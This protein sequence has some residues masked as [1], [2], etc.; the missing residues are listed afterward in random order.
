MFAKAPYARWVSAVERADAS[1]ISHAE[2]KNH[3][4]LRALAT[5]AVAIG[6]WFAPVPVGVDPKAWQLFAIFAATIVGL[7]LQPLPMGAVVLVGV[8]LSTVTG[9]LHIEEA[10]NGYA[11]ATVW[12]IVAAFLFARAFSKT[13]LGRR[14]AYL[15]IRAF[16]HKTLGLAYALGLADLVLAPGIP[17]GAART[18]GVLFPVVKSLATTYGSEPGPSA[19][20]IGRFLMLSAYQ[21]HAVTCAMFLTSMVAN[22]LIAEL[23]RKT[24]G[25]D[26][27]WSGWALAA[28]VPGAISLL[29]LPYV[30]LR[31]TRPTI[32]ETPE[33]A[34]LARNELQ[35][36]G[37]VRRE[38]WVVLGVFLLA[39][40]LWITGSITHLNAT[41]VALLGLCLMLAL[42]AI[43]W[44]DVLEERAAWDALIWF[45]GLVGMATMLSKLGLMTWFSSHVGQY[46]D[47]WSWPLALIVLV[48]VY[49]YSHYLFASLAAHATAFFVPFLTVAVAAGA[50][51]YM[52]ALAFAFS[53]SLCASL[54]H[55]GGGPSPVYWGAG[56]ADVKQWWS[57]GLVASLLHILIWIGIGSVWWR[58]LGL[59]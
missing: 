37:S 5:A 46:V 6:I 19:D 51:P 45:G 54:T 57:V 47:G 48:C 44:Q 20:R 10:L 18:G 34:A 43:S 56:Y 11:N 33:A 14:V 36:M 1:R 23:T 13:G 49:I 3:R 27:T 26:I 55:Y 39:F 59:F 31:L 35:R 32:R 38:E 22:P 42:G 12:L 25:I 4:Q 53:S 7:I 15:F 52:A 2:V 16:G 30:I 29:I 41:A 9:T 17:S 24:L 8:T 21:V 50:P 58:V 28:S 40:V